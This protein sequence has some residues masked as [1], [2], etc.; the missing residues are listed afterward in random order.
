VTLGQ[1]AIL[2]IFI[3]D[4]YVIAHGSS[5]FTWLT[6][7]SSG[8]VFR[9][10]GLDIMLDEVNG[11]NV[12]QRF[13][14]YGARVPAGTY[15]LGASCDGTGGRNFYAI[16]AIR[17]ALIA[18]AERIGG[19]TAG[20][21]G[22]VCGPGPGGLQEESPA[23]MDRPVSIS[24]ARDY[25]WRDVPDE[26]LGADYVMTYNDDKMPRDTYNDRQWPNNPYD[27]SYSVTLHESV[28]LCLF[29]DRRYVS[30]HGD[31]PF[32]WLTD[33]SC[34]AV[35]EDTGLEIMLDELGGRNVL[36]P[37]SVYSANVPAGTYT[38]G[39]ACDGDA[40][41]NFY[42]IA[43]AIGRG[44]DFETGDFSSY[45]WQH[46]GG[47][48]PWQIISEQ[49][50]SGTYSA[51]AGYISEDKD[52]VLAVTLDCLDG[53]V[54]FSVKT[55]SE[56]YCDMRIFTIDGWTVGE[57]SGELDW[58]EVSFP[59]TAGIHTFEWIYAKDGS[60]DEGE[61]TAWIDDIRFP[62]K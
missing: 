33:G 49:A 37:F 12:L 13:H 6:D 2:Y 54:S 56:E 1:S 32:G 53:D 62:A 55:S 58:T 43:A 26:L 16:A 52:S 14:I 30:T 18:G 21:P 7:G 51:Q 4:R 47:V 25:C 50:H 5:P 59:V 31:P 46:G 60:V 40:D 39:P 29:I 61:D 41:R 8:A 11:R 35:F 28:E 10:T 34:G 20:E 57:W 22:I 36:Q 38:F 19:V 27:V 42:A 44:E 3:D 17:G 23:F 9:D 15:T 45:D 48:A 24:D